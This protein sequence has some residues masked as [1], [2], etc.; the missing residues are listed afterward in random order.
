MT[1]FDKLIESNLCLGCG[2]CESLG[3]DAGY[4]VSLKTNGFFSVD[5]AETRDPLFERD[6]V[7]CCPSI[8]I[9][10]VGD[11]TV[12]GQHK[13]IYKVHSNDP[14]IRYSASSGGFITSICTYL[15]QIGWVDKILQ[16]GRVEKDP[17]L[18]ELKVVD[19]EEDII[20]N[21]SSRYAPALMFANLKQLLD[22]STHSYAF[23]GK[24][25]DVLCVKNFVNVYPQ[26]KE[27]VKFTIAI[28]CGGM[29]SY[30]ATHKL[31]STFHHDDK[32]SDVRYRGNGWPGEFTVSYCDGAR[33]AVPYQESWM[34]Y[35]SKTVHHRCKVCPDSIGT[36]ADVSVGDAWAL[37]DG[38]ATFEEKEGE[39]CVIIRSINAQIQ[40]DSM[41][42]K[43]IISAASLSEEYLNAIQPNHIRKR[44][45]SG[46]KIL[47]IKLI[48]P[49]LIKMSKTGIVSLMFQYNILKG[50]RDL[51]GALRRYK[52]WKK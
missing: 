26:Y 5:V 19:N 36:I 31:I 52:M 2:L 33:Y 18:N 10:G 41:L 17:I 44:T 43:G 35:F 29:P 22:S 49:H 32:V 9:V 37:K 8:T 39:S 30:N 46:Y 6:I 15:L 45:S 25:C 14:S 3:K 4:K 48:S 21:C 7:D 42:K 28:F 40:F 16:V 20:K 1:R 51:W 27:R 12:W 13:G 24:S 38:H 47:G 23:V 50:F 34:N 11:T